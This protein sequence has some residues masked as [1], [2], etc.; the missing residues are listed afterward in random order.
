MKRK[1]LVFE[2]KKRFILIVDM[3]NGNTVYDIRRSELPM[4]R[5]SY[6]SEWIMQLMTKTWID[7]KTLYD[8][9][10]LIS[11]FFP[12]NKI[13]WYKTFYIV[14]KKDY[15]HFAEEQL[16]PETAF[17]AEDLLNSIEFGQNQTS[18]IIDKIVK[19][20]LEEYNLKY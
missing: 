15:L 17:S 7:T 10:V 8:L 16:L 13:D 19:Q 18:D 3:N 6:Y 11:T 4:M 9:A 1:K 2:V 20:R 5:D 14:E 12:E